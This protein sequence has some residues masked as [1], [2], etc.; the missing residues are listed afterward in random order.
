MNPRRRDNDRIALELE[1]L[2]SPFGGEPYD[3]EAARALAYLLAHADAAYPRLLALVRRARGVNL[4]PLVQALGHFGRPESLG[5]LNE[6]LHQGAPTLKR[7]SATALARHPQE[8][9]LELLLSALDC[10]DSGVVA[11]AADALGKRG[12]P[13]ASEKLTDLL[14]HPDPE[15]RYQAVLSLAL[16]GALQREELLELRDHDADEDVRALAR[17]LEE[18]G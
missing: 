3:S 2:Q 8:R 17:E 7:A 6:L 5:P 16:L 13:R 4:H 10:A 12:D 1:A 11:A 15:V 14:Q 9:A 18:E